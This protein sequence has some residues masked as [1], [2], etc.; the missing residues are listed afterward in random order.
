MNRFFVEIE[1]LGQRDRFYFKTIEAR[2]HFIGVQKI[3][4]S[5]KVVSFGSG[6]WSHDK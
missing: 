1:A 3:F 6:D 2:N 5:I 4:K